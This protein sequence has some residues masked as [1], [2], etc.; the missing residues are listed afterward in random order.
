MNN[1]V[2]P[3]GLENDKAARYLYVE[4]IGGSIKLIYL[5]V[6]RNASTLVCWAFPG[7]VLTVL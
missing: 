5:M 3:N 2:L 1:F 7:S 4:Y 6:V